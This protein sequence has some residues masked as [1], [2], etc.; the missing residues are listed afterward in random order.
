MKKTIALIVL[1]LAGSSL[2][3]MRAGLTQVV[4]PARPQTASGS[5]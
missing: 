3:A 4:D 1:L 2:F 5:R